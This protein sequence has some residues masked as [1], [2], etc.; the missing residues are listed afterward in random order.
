M[1]WCPLSQ[2]P[3]LPG[4][5]QAPTELNTSHITPESFVSRP[6]ANIDIDPLIEPLPAVLR[7]I[8]IS[9]RFYNFCAHLCVKVKESLIDGLIEDLIIN[10]GPG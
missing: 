4:V 10:I 2:F 8:K 3:P 9:V 5:C 6:A 1:P 7:F